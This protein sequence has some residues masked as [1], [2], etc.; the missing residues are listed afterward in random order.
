VA[1][2]SDWAQ[3]GEQLSLEQMLNSGKARIDSKR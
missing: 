1:D 2:G 3:N